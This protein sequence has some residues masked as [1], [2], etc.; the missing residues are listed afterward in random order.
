MNQTELKELEE[1]FDI[2]FLWYEIKHYAT[3]DEIC[4]EGEAYRTQS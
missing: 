3:E 4:R 2:M 1:S